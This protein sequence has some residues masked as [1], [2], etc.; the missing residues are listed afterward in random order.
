MIQRT[1]FDILRDMFSDERDRDFYKKLYTYEQDGW[2]A[3]YYLYKAGM[4]DEFLEKFTPEALYTQIKDFRPLWSVYQD[5]RY[6]VEIVKEKRDP[7]LLA[8]Y[9][10]LES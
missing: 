9:I 7:Y 3:G 4:Y 6:G 5:F 10:L 1:G 2:E 8:R